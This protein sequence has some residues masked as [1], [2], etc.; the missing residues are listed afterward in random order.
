MG[1]KSIKT[2]NVPIILVRTHDKIY[3]Y[4]FKISKEKFPSIKQ[5]DIHYIVSFFNV[6][7]Y[8][9]DFEMEKIFS[10]KDAV[11]E[12]I[13]RKKKFNNPT[14][15]KDASRDGLFYEIKFQFVA[16]FIKKRKRNLQ[17]YFIQFEFMIGDTMVNNGGF[18][19]KKYAYGGNVEKDVGKEKFVDLKTYNFLLQNIV[20]KCGSAEVVEEEV[21]GVVKEWEKV[22]CSIEDIRWPSASI[23]KNTTIDTQMMMMTTPSSSPE[24]KRHNKINTM[25]YYGD[26][27]FD[28]FMQEYGTSDFIDHGKSIEYDVFDMFIEKLDE[29]EVQDH[30]EVLNY[31]PLPKKIKRNEYQPEEHMFDMNNTN[32]VDFGLGSG[33]F[34]MD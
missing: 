14:V 28:R 7:N 15:I 26:Y 30:Y 10:K 20:R 27:E 17:M 8:P 31:E 16:N 5:E 4:E 24:N 18:L 34:D 1:K 9:N 11:F 23:E 3:S 25:N 29:Q 32:I 12:K 22:E 21:N 6:P 13:K 33:C 19:F 2:S